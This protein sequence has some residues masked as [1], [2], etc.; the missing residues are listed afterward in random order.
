M[1]ALVSLSD[2][3]LVVGERRDGLLD[4]VGRPE[5][6]QDVWIMTGSRSKV[7]NTSDP[8]ELAGMPRGQSVTHLVPR[9]VLSDRKYHSVLIDVP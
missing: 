2:I 7:V 8:G 3:E 4:V 5:R 6:V 9:L 1:G